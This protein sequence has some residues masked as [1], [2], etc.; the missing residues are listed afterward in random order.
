MYGHR[1]NRPAQGQVVGSG[2]ICM[3]KMDRKIMSHEMSRTVGRRECDGGVGCIYRWGSRCGAVCGW[4]RA[5]AG[6]WWYS[7]KQRSAGIN[8]RKDE[9]PVRVGRGKLQWWSWRPVLAMRPWA[10]Q[11]KTGPKYRYMAF[12]GQASWA[13]PMSSRDCLIKREYQ[14]LSL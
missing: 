13:S 12:T 9:L 6:L 2:M 8:R 1:V 3:Q 5:C 7:N 4:K 14:H 10:F 11:A